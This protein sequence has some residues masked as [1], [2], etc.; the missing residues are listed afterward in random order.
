MKLTV[1]ARLSASILITSLLLLGVALGAILVAYNHIGLKAA[2][3]RV[4]DM[5]RD[6][7]DDA[8]FANSGRLRLDDD[9]LLYSEGVSVVFLEGDGKR[10]AGVYPLS[11]PADVPILTDRERRLEG[12]PGD[13]LVYDVDS[14]DG[15]Y[16]RAVMSL[17]EHQLTMNK[18]TLIAAALTLGF[19][20]TMAVLAWLMARRAFKPVAELV[21]HAESIHGGGQLDER[22]PVPDTHDEIEQLARTFN[23][24][25]RRLDDSFRAER[26]FTS[27]VSH[28]LRTPVGAIMAQCELGLVGDEAERMEALDAIY[29]TA[30]H[31]STLV[32]RLLMLA[33]ADQGRQVLHIERLELRPLC[34]F[35]CQ[36]L[37]ERAEERSV[38]LE[39]VPG[40]DA[41]EIDGDSALIVSLITNLVGNA[42]NYSDMDKPKRWVR[43]SVSGS[44]GDARISV[45]DNG[46]GIPEEHVAHIFDRFYRVDSARG[47]EG[48]GL[49]LCLCAWIA[50]AHGGRVEVESRLGEGS[51]F[52]AILTGASEG[53]APACDMSGRA[54]GA[55]G[56]GV[57]G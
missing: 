32:N 44:D 2:W 11:F 55:H 54:A 39:L 41:P 43:V 15:F 14:G 50:A 27:D 46:L 25:F 28:E 33:R 51:C 40:E 31:M 24:M 13:W 34:E 6:A 53:A 36:S 9:V 38:E 29:A 52:T 10:L 12:K 30:Q 4:E 20:L 18:M 21:R 45:A 1:K 23:A 16:V 57:A 17:Y 5:A 19:A 22:L 37:E 49:G 47:G 56:T 42:I 7:E 26:Q 48:T 8:E 3:A 35:A